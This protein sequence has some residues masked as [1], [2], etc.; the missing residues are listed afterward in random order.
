M[1]IFTEANKITYAKAVDVNLFQTLLNVT[2][3]KKS[4]KWRIINKII[5][6]PLVLNLEFGRVS[7][8]WLLDYVSKLYETL[9]DDLNAEQ[10][11]PAIQGYSEDNFDKLIYELIPFK[12]NA[13]SLN[14]QIH[15]KILPLIQQMN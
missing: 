11:P 13:M 1:V 5:F 4:V 12:K 3:A 9:P 8:T 6:L 10:S 14:L 7:Q 15:G 2:S